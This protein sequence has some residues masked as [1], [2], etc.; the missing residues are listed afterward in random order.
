MDRHAGL[1]LAGTPIS[2]VESPTDAVVGVSAD[3]VITTW[4]RG[5]QRLFGY[6]SQEVVGRPV[7]ILAPDEEVRTPHE[8]LHELLAGADVD[9]VETDRITKD[10]RRLR[11]LASLSAVTDHH[12]E[13]VGILGVYR[14][15]RD[16]QPAPLQGRLHDRR[17]SRRGRTLE[18]Q[19][20]RP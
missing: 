5:A 3:G 8:L 4:G 18:W 1:E 17:R 7:T 11:V 13:T 15:R 12:G 19:P 6:E 16:D 10:G 14:V 2:L 9:R 20:V